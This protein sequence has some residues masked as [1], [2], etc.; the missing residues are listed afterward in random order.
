MPRPSPAPRLRT[1]DS[2]KRGGVLLFIAT[3]RPL[4][5]CRLRRIDPA[6]VDT[7]DRWSARLLDV[8]RLEDVSARALL[9][10]SRSAGPFILSTFSSAERLR[11]TGLRHITRTPEYRCPQLRCMRLFCN[12]NHLRLPGCQQTRWWKLVPE[13]GDAAPLD[14]RYGKPSPHE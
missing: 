1:L 3:S 10:S 2:W 11:L 13:P 14:P 8:E 7:L 6:D 4:P 9:R 12:A 5:R